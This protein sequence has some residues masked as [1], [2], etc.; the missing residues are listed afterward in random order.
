MSITDKTKPELRAAN[1]IKA[2]EYPT[3]KVPY[4]VLNKRYRVSQKVID[5][6]VSH[7]DKSIKEL[8][9]TSDLQGV[10]RALDNVVEKLQVVKRKADESMLDE[11]DAAQVCKKRL[12]HLKEMFELPYSAAAMNVWRKKRLDR[13]L[14]DHLLR[15]GH[16]ET[17]A[18][19]TKQSGLENLTNLELFM[20]A[21]RVEE[22]LLAGDTSK[23]L[24][25]CHDNKSKL[26]KMKSTLEFKLRQQE[27]IEL[28]K[29]NRGSEAIEHSRKYLSNIDEA[30]QQ[31]FLNMMGLLCQPLD[32]QREPYKSLLDK[33]RW[34]TLVEQFKR[35]NYNLFQ[36]NSVSVFSVA[37][38]AGLSALKSRYCYIVYSKKNRDCPICSPLLN[39]LAKNLP[40][41]H[42][43]QSKLICPISGQPV[44][45]HNPPM[46]FEEGYIFGEQSIRQ[47]IARDGYFSCPISRRKYNLCDALK[48]FLL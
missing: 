25:W 37:L 30:Q 3:L 13:M 31:E 22:S 48:V 12:D 41:P 23:C 27:F 21:R 34:L 16:Y 45:E 9:N 32:T 47:A 17:A 28:Y 44:N 46:M 36:L 40:Y 26:R 24:A 29:Q 33:S 42:C 43:S 6:E 39:E 15:D 20:V 8:R 4:E 5:R 2:M 11:Q 10:H 18:R 1:D 19:L 38:Q 35:D 7:L 14:V